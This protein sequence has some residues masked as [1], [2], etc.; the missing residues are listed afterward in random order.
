LVISRIIQRPKE[1]GKREQEASCADDEY[2]DE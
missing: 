1:C 2:S